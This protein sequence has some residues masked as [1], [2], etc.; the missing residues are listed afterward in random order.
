MFIDD[1]NID[2]ASGVADVHEQLNGLNIY[3]NPANQVLFIKLKNDEKAKKRFLKEADIPSDHPNIIKCREA[4]EQAGVS[5][6]E[7]WESLITGIGL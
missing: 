1:I 3:P 7:T 6:F 4:F 2:V 5:H